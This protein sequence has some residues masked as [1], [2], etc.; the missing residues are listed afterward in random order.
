MVDSEVMKRAKML[1]NSKGEDALEHANHMFEDMKKT[2]DE[3]DY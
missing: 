2:G 3:E 1:V